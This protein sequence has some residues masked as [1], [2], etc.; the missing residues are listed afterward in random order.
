MIPSMAGSRTYIG[1]AYYDSRQLV[2][3]SAAAPKKVMGLGK[4]IGS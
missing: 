3:V 2:T 4:L 1:P